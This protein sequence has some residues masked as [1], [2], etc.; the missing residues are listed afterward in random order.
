MFGGLV[1]LDRMNWGLHQTWMATV[2]SKSHGQVS[3]IHSDTSRTAQIAVVYDQKNLQLF[4]NGTPSRHKMTQQSR[5]ETIDELPEL[6]PFDMGTMLGIDF[7]DQWNRTFEGELSEIRISKI[8]RYTE[9]YQP[10]SHL[11]ADEQTIA[12]YHFDEGT[13]DLLKDSSG[14]G[15]HGRIIGAKWVKTDGTT[16]SKQT[17]LNDGPALLFDK[18]GSYVDVPS[19]PVDFNQPF[20]VESWCNPR[21]VARTKNRIRVLSTFGPCQLSIDQ[22]REIAQAV[23]VDVLNQEKPLVSREIAIHNQLEKEELHIALQWTGDDLLLFVNGVPHSKN[24]ET[25][26]HHENPITFI[27]RVTAASKSQKLRIGNFMDEFTVTQSED[28]HFSSSIHSFRISQGL[29]YR[30]AF[31]PEK[32]TPDEQTLALYKFNEGTGD[33]LKDSSGNGHHGRIIGAK[34]VRTKTHEDASSSKPP[35]SASQYMLSFDGV[36]DYVELP[37]F[38]K[39][40]SVTVEA[41]CTPDRY[42]HSQVVASRGFYLS[43]SPEQESWCLTGRGGGRDQFVHITSAEKIKFGQ[44]VTLAGVYDGKNLSLFVDGKLVDTRPSSR[45]APYFRIGAVT[46]PP[47]RLFSGT[48]SAVRISRGA[49][50]NEDYS[51]TESWQSDENTLA[52]YQFSEGSSDLLKDASGNRHHGTIIGAKWIRSDTAKK[53]I[54]QDSTPSASGG[55]ALRFDGTNSEPF[56]AKL[57]NEDPIEEYT[58]EAWVTSEGPS[59]TKHYVEVLGPKTGAVIRLSQNDVSGWM[60]YR[61]H[62]VVEESPGARVPF[63]RERTHIANVYSTGKMGLFVNGE[64][65]GSS[66][67]TK[68]PMQFDTLHLGPQF[69]DVNFQGIVDEMRLSRVARYTEDFQPDERFEPDDKTVVLYHFDEGTGDIAKDSSGNG[70]HGKIIGAKWVK[71]P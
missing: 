67:V 46:G 21:D 12:L 55:Y 65:K 35:S 4:V 1:N 54:K 22:N 28:G 16:F 66:P 13:G 34:W 7:D 62:A 50:Y 24:F 10:R 56:V 40:E 63:S 18:P 48:I 59:V 53:P 3:L 68:P 37:Q 71:L 31:T 44:Q 19:I 49:R 69:K 36:D 11:E 33:L 17:V 20:C 42:A 52:L 45:P 51:V 57:E 27:K 61:F 2:P 5:T 32:F 39:N 25:W 9:P 15:H 58:V 47:A 14:N 43:M 8:A 26:K 70:H 38:E 23:I 64:F 29:R 60:A 6:S 30:I 41:I